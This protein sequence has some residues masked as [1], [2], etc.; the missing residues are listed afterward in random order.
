MADEVGRL[1]FTVDTGPLGQA[2]AALS[3][4]NQ[5]GQ[6]TQTTMNN[7]AG[8][9]GRTS[10]VWDGYGNNTAQAA[11]A[12]AGLAQAMTQGGAAW[13]NYWANVT[14][15]TGHLTAYTAAAG[16]AATATARVG[17]QATATNAVLGIHNQQWAN[18]QF[19]INDIVT[20]LASGQ[21]PF[22][23]LAQQG[24][25]V[26]QILNGPAGIVGTL[27]AIG[28]RFAALITP[29]RLVVG[30]LT[31]ITAAATMMGSA[32]SSAQREIAV[33]LS[34]LGRGAGTTPEGINNISRSIAESN[35]MTVGAAREM[36]LA[37]AQTGD[38]GAREFE[39]ISGVIKGLAITMGTDVAKA[40]ELMG[41][42]LSNPLKGFD[43]L[44]QKL[45]IGSAATREYIASLM[46]QGRGEEARAALLRATSTALA[47]TNQ[48]TSLATR[49]WERFKSNL[50]QQAEAIAG[51]IANIFDPDLETRIKRLNDNIRNL[52]GAGAL[53]Y[54]FSKEIAEIDELLG[55]LNLLK[56]ANYDTAKAASEA[57]KLQKESIKGIAEAAKFVPGADRE[58]ELRT[59]SGTMRRSLDQNRE[60]GGLLLTEGQVKVL[61]EAA[62]RA[63]LQYRRIANAGGIVALTKQDIARANELEIQS[64]MALTQA[65]EVAAAAARAAFDAEKQG[66]DQVTAARQAAAVVRAQQTAESQRV[67]M[68]QQA[69]LGMGSRLAAAAQIQ[70]IAGIR[71]NAQLQEEMRLRQQGIDVMSAESQE[72]I[73]N[74][75]AIAEQRTRIADLAQATD[76]RARGSDQLELIRAET[77]MLGL[78]SIER[79]RRMSILQG[80]MRAREE[81]RRGNTENAAAIREYSSATANANAN[82]ERQRSILEANKRAQE[83]YARAVAQATQAILAQG[84]SPSLDLHG[85]MPGASSTTRAGD[86]QQAQ[87]VTTA[88]T[89]DRWQVAQA[90]AMYG[91]GNYTWGAVGGT[92]LLGG[93]IRAQAF[94]DREKMAVQEEQVSNQFEQFQ[95]QQRQLSFQLGGQS[96]SR[97]SGDLDD[98]TADIRK[99]IELL[100]DQK[101]AAQKT[102]ENTQSMKEHMLNP[103]AYD[104][105]KNPELF[106]GGANKIFGLGET[107]VM[108][109]TDA[110]E[111]GFDSQIDALE[112]QIEAINDQ[113]EYLQDQ[114]DRLGELAFLEQ[115][116]VDL[117]TAQLN[118]LKQI[119]ANILSMVSPST[120][121]EFSSI[122]GAQQFESSTPLTTMQKAALNTTSTQSSLPITFGGTS[123]LPWN[124]AIKRS[125]L[126]FASGGG[127]LTGSGG[128]DSQQFNIRMTPGEMML[129]LTP[130]QQ[131][132]IFGGGSGGNRKINVTQIFPSVR[133]EATLKESRGSYARE[134]R[135]MMSGLN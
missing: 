66:L 130:D 35:Q 59:S 17:Q 28:A 15:G 98:Q 20:G 65:Q 33:G 132:R 103:D 10:I 39:K 56:I 85:Q 71:L 107:E 133:D 75:G 119:N 64:I 116:G 70:G 18:L 96:L 129:G 49:A 50:S 72:R 55:R 7:I 32:F 1:S 13:T 47:D 82:L 37:L 81:E 2:N 23:V 86:W 117:N 120:R 79:E 52:Q 68:S 11:R 9:V 99:Q 4:L 97:Q 128:T 69:E 77:A 5:T 102:A 29:V 31:A 93:Q 123:T 26:F 91:K 53:D 134:T 78:N 12:T 87:S 40:T 51:S 57:A 14:A 38:I 101:E 54:D 6:T 30:G 8:A 108:S 3:Q 111:A 67:I 34:G 46:A 63:E 118:E 106:Y 16:N 127:I 105:S 124:P 104:L 42:S 60:S 135:K 58:M 24:G 36:S 122:L 41:A 121:Q 61:E 21:S 114:A 110:I 27:Q 80:E 109:N 92:G 112:Q 43:D 131:R 88:V 44:N 89:P 73:R 48:A 90:D 22:T 19:Q 25:Q 76:T 94:P 45:N 100:E 126:G 115:H 113:K 62:N 74:A 95:S 83:E 125:T 84:R